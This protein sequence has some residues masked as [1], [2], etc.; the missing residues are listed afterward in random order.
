[1]NGVTSGLVTVPCGIPQG[2]VLGPTLFLLRINDFY[3][4]SN[5]LEFHLFADDANLFHRHRDIDTLKHNINAELNNV[6]IWL[7]SNKL[8]LNIE[9]QVSS[10]FT[11]LRKS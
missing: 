8:S 11:L 1:M 9:S 10:Y 5:F 6:N 2:S 7:C 4:C 3:Y